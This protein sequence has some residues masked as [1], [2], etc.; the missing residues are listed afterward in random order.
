[1]GHPDL[2]VILEASEQLVDTALLALSAQLGASVLSVLAGNDVLAVVP[3]DLLEAVAYSE[4][5]DAEIE[6]GWVDV[7]GSLLVDRVWASRK[8]DTLW[9][10]V[11]LRERGSAWKHLGVDIE[12]TKA[13]GDQVGVLRSE[14]SV[15]APVAN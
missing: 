4:N 15:F 10:E 13:A 11:Q 9:S 2:E 6:H 7:G 12:L 5:W 1:M 3:C 8:D 14:S